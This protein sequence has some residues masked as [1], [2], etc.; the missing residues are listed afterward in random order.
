MNI[1]GRNKISTEFSMS[2][3]TDIVF[4]LLVF[5][6]LTAN[7][8]NALDLLLP[9]AKGKSTNVQNIS[10]SINKNLQ[11][12]VDSK[13]TSILTIEEDLKNALK[14]KNV[15]T[16]TIIL[17]VEEGV[18]IEKAVSVMDIANKNHYKLILA[19]RPN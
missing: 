5:F 1:K 16:P 18:P 3:M 2:S 14:N 7:S 4:L 19:V 6:M 10:V 12:F 13:E 15:K 17:R 9:K 8:P 11:Y